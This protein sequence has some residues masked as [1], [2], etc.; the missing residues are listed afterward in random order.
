M[1]FNNCESISF[2]I[3]K[4]FK[5]I[6]LFFRWAQG[7]NGGKIGYIDKDVI[8]YQSGSNVKFIAEDGAETVFNFKGNGVGPFA[9]HPTNK[10]FAVAERCLNPKITVY[11]Y[12]TFREAA[13]LKGIIVLFTLIF[14]CCN[15]CNLSMTASLNVII[16]YINFCFGKIMLYCSLFW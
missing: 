14:A 2:H 13:V 4:Y 12:P 7:Y 8:C 3:F 11:V 1:A 10:C 5:K 6:I 15:Y 9:V 16:F